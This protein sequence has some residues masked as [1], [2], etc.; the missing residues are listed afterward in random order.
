MRNEFN[1][2]S[3]VGYLHIRGEYREKTKKADVSLSLDFVPSKTLLLE[4][5]FT[6]EKPVSIGNCSLGIYNHPQMESNL[7]CRMIGK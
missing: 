6:N 5:L 4:K 1:W 7:V 3:S 2:E